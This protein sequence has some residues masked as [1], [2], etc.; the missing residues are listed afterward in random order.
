MED[1][2]LKL[3]VL[4]IILKRQVFDSV[5]KFVTDSFFTHGCNVDY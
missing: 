2:N 3:Y 5:R 1:G 4:K